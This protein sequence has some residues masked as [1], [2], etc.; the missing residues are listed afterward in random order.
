MRSTLACA[1]TALAVTLTLPAPAQASHHRPKPPS[2]WRYRHERQI[3]RCF[4]ARAADRFGQSRSEAYYIA[5]RESRFHWRA[6]NRSSGAAGLYQFMPT[7]WAHSPYRHRSPYNPRWA[8]LA[9]M[10]YWAHG[11]K[12]HWAT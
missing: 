2:C 3:S 10:W 7:T 12:H 1:M 6:T 8:A 5:W 9:A 4:I 11:G